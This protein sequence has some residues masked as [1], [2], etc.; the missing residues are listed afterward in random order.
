MGPT[1]DIAESWWGATEVSSIGYRQTGVAFERSRS[2][3]KTTPKGGLFSVKEVRMKGFFYGK[4][5]VFER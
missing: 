3:G 1:P 4:N 2:L 5:L